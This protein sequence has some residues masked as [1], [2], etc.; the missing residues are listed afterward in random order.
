MKKTT[1]ATY[2]DFL[3]AIENMFT[4]KQNVL[5]IIDDFNFYVNGAYS[6]PL[7]DLF[8]MYDENFES[9]HGAEKT[10]ELID[11]GTVGTINE[12]IY[13]ADGS[14]LQA[15]EN[16]RVY[17]LDR[18]NKYNIIYNPMLNVYTET[19]K[20]AVNVLE[21]ANPIVNGKEKA[22]APTLPAPKKKKTFWKY[23][24]FLVHKPKVKTL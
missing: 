19:L 20:T 23:L 11:N 12:Y 18:K 14:L 2:L 24:G 22:V 21:D 13:K 3:L 9:I 17:I 4:N 15:L 5:P 10:K 16:L 1:K 8:R 7:T 6:T